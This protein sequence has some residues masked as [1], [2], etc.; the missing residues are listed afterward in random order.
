L[1][2]TTALLRAGLELDRI[3]PCPRTL[4]VEGKPFRNFEGNAAGA[5]PFSRDFAESCNTAFVSLA[6][7]L[8]TAALTKTAED[9]GLGGKLSLG[10]PV[11]DSSV[12]P[13][14]SAVGQA[15]MMIG[16]DRIV[17]TPLAMAGVAATVAAG[18]WNAPRLLTEDRRARGPALPERDTLRTL[19]RRVV[20]SGTGTALRGVR[21]EVLGKSGTAEFGGGDP[22]PTHA[23]F[24]AAREDIALAVLVEN[25]RSGGAVAAPIAARFFAALDT[26]A[27]S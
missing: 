26:D 2:S 10:L 7:E 12:P 23:W 13:P 17:A 21:G 16:Q 8:R 4:A 1:V 3:V 22:P 20:T 6:R 24:I 18:R 25:G 9:F 14:T 15:A 5:V 19:M 27:S 11:A